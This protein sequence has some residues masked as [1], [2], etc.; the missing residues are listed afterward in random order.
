MAKDK[1]EKVSLTRILVIALLPVMIYI[2]YCIGLLGGQEISLD[3]LGWML[4]YELLHPFP[5]GLRQ[6]PGMQCSLSS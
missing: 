5:R 6:R 3:S 1:K 4:R 2:A